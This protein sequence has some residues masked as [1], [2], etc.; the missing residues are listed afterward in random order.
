MAAAA[1]GGVP[2]DVRILSEHHATGT[3]WVDRY[4][5]VPFKHGGRGFD[6]AD[7]FGLY[8]LILAT[9]SGIAP[10]TFDG[11]SAAGD[12]NATLRAIN[13]AIAAGLWQ[14]IE[15]DPVKVAQRFDAILMAGVHG[16]PVHIGCAVG[17]GRVLHSERATGPRCVRLDDFKIRGRITG[18]MRGVYRPLFLPQSQ[19]AAA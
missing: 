12:L 5:T 17:D 2:R 9:E 3:R 4:M 16:A 18:P 13:G 8:A 7:C 6:G 10:P 11:L 15:G 1:A 19:I 14:K